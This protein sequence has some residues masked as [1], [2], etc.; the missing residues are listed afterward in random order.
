ME[1]LGLPA[2]D[3]LQLAGL[4]ARG[5]AAHLSRDYQ[6]AIDFYT[7]ATEIETRLPYNEPA[8]WYQPVAQSLGASLFEAGR[9]QEARTAFRR[10]LVQAPNSGW[11]LYG[12]AATERKIG[13]TL[14]AKAADAALERNWIGERRW[15]QLNRL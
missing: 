11:A 2:Q 14:E 15:L 6:S 12:L 5:R 3:L 13:N 1:S 9:L 4:M 8:F 7:S 10:A